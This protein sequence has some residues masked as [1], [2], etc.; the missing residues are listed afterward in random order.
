MDRL[1]SEKLETKICS[2]PN[3]GRLGGVSVIRNC[4]QLKPTPTLPNQGGRLAFTLAEVLIT[5]GVIGVVSAMTLPSV[6]NNF[7]VSAWESGLKKSY[8]TITNGFHA[9]ASENGGD[10]RNSGLFD[11]VDDATFSDRMDEA[12]NKHFKVLKTCKVDDTNKCPGYKVKSLKGNTTYTMMAP[13]SGRFIVF[14]EDG[15]IFRTQNN[16]CELTNYSDES[17]LKMICSYITVDI[18]GEKGPNTF[19]KDV[20]QFGSMDE[21]GDIYPDTSLEWAKSK[22][23]GNKALTYIEYWRNRPGQCGTPNKKISEETIASISGLNCLA[24][25]MENGWKM[26]YLK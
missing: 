26:D 11:D 4:F 7:Q 14:L 2:S 3:K 16:K 5:L 20:F 8:A 15:S 9:I 13:T 1:T 17:K 21:K 24:R 22:V 25:I 23:G 19:G 18:N 12:M 6:I 10:L